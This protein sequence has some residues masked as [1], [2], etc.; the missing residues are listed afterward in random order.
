MFVDTKRVE[1]RDDKGNVIGIRRKMDLGAVSYIQ[2]VEPRERLIEL[3]AVNIIDWS[4]PDFAGVPC[5][6]ENIRR[7]DYD[8]PILEQVGDKIA[9]LNPKLSGRQPADPLPATTPAESTSR[10]NG[11]RPAALTTST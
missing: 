7:L 8:E 4:G 1:V 10:A 2:G 9:E 3:Y 6:P 5:T 11:H